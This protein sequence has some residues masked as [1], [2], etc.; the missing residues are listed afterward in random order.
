MYA[1]NGHI[2]LTVQWKKFTVV[3]ELTVG[4][5]L[6]VGEEQTVGKNLL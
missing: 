5:K 4:G 3:E 6:T 1:A 2:Q